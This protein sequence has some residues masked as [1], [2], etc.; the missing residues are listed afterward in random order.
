MSSSL[1][2][3]QQQNGSSSNDNDNVALAISASC[4]ICC[5]I[6]SMPEICYPL[7]CPT[8]GCNDYN[9]CLNCI[10]AMLQS[11]ADGYQQASDGSHQVKF[12]ISCPICRCKY[13]PLA[14]VTQVVATKSNNKSPPKS[15][16]QK[17]PDYDQS[18]I[19][20]VILLRR[21]YAVQLLLNCSGWYC[22]NNNNTR[23]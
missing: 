9:I 15:S 8:V 13:N 7:V 11:E 1:E 22:Y 5:N 6:M 17:Q 4:P 18:I 12:C 14:A 19:H 2:E 23:W 21:V 16:P 3:K 10:N 20:H